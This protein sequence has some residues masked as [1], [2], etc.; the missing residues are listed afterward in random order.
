M[1]GKEIPWHSRPGGLIAL[2]RLPGLG[3]QRISLPHKLGRTMV[4]PDSASYLDWSRSLRSG[5]Y[6]RWLLGGAR[7]P[8]RA[9]ERFK[10]LR[11]VGTS[12]RQ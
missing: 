2:G 12:C 3:V 1:V 11:L 9:A 6:L 5:W 8:Y 10:V 4:I 7:P